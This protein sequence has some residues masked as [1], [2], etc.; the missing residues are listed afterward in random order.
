MTKDPIC[1]MTADEAT[2]F[3]A[4]RSGQTFYFCSEHC[5]QIFLAETARRNPPTPTAMGTGKACCDGGYT[6][7]QSEHGEHIHHHDHAEHEQGRIRP[8]STAKYFC[9]MCAGVESDKPG[10]CP[11][12]G[13]ALER[14]PA[15]KPPNKTVYTCP[16]HPEVEQDHPGNCPKCGMALEPKTV[17]ADTQEDNSELHSITRRFWVGAALTLPVFVV[18]MAHMVPAWS[19]AEWVG[20][21]LSRWGQFILSTPVVL[22]AGWPFFVRGWRSLVNRSLNM[23][24]LVALGVGA[25]YAFSA[26]A[27]LF[28]Q[29]FPPAA[30]HSGKPALY[31]EAAAVITMLV[32]LGQVLE[33]RARQRTGGAIKA[34]LGLAP[35]TAR[36]VTP[37]GGEDVPLDAV[38]P[39]DHL[40]VRPGEKIPVDGEVVEGR[41]SVDESM[42]TGE[43]LPVEKTIGAKVSGATVNTTGSIA[44][45][46]FRSLL[47][48]V[49]LKPPIDSGAH[50][51]VRNALQR[52][53]V[54]AHR[55]V[56]AEFSAQAV[57]PRDAE[58]WPEEDRRNA[59]IVSF[60]SL[61]CVASLGFAGNVQ[62][63]G[64]CV[65]FVQGE[66][67][68]RSAPPGQNH[69]RSDNRNRPWCGLHIAH[70]P[71]ETRVADA[72][73]LRYPRFHPPS[74]SRGRGRAR[75]SRSPSRRAA[76]AIRPPPPVNGHCCRSGFS[77]PRA[78]SRRE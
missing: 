75:E 5:R 3:R 67:H 21:E 61:E 76:E 19:H 65:A 20:G 63:Q 59:G 78:R 54:D 53:V 31:F 68:P 37:H 11:K 34:L 40:R 1:G 74:R 62:L 64:N 8:S 60:R 16:M 18:A 14:N 42:L 23:F 27:I 4:E 39:S 29:A 77:R 7:P 30:G 12:C 52:G 47:P 55:Q 43:S 9:P 48:P 10:D 2:A 25:A 51:V 72:R 41:T 56:G 70:S 32:L 49:I 33:L 57:A 69:W 28:P 36:R 58:L 22:W 17:T 38:H 66:I 24:T 44:W 15:S 6:H 45:L 26:V 50:A 71:R 35:K 73:K 46:I 13:M